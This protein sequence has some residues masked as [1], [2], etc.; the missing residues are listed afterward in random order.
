MV[1]RREPATRS[2]MHSGTHA[3]T[4]SLYAAFTNP[5]NVN[6][7]KRHH[8]PAPLEISDSFTF[9]NDRISTT[10]GVSVKL[11]L[12]SVAFVSLRPRYTR[13]AIA[14]PRFKVFEWK[15]DF[16]SVE[17][18]RS[19]FE[20]KGKATRYY[21]SPW[22]FSFQRSPLN[23]TRRRTGPPLVEFWCKRTSLVQ[24]RDVFRRC[25]SCFFGSEEKEYTS[26]ILL[27]IHLVLFSVRLLAAS[28]RARDAGV[29]LGFYNKDAAPLSIAFWRFLSGGFIFLITCI[30]CCLITIEMLKKGKHRLKSVN[31]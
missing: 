16:Q 2:S 18:Y 25:E 22:R 23:A 10:S 21:N 29:G 7:C 6:P 1:L 13:D 31:L 14:H 27:V 28:F 30:V 5:A 11:T 8:L 12:E 20:P 3:S 9:E 17:S 26:S 19:L 15:N 24:L 4:Y